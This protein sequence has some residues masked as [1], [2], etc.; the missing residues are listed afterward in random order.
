MA[1]WRYA[2]ANSVRHTKISGVRLGTHSVEAAF[3]DA[4]QIQHWLAELETYA[5]KQAS[6]A[7]L[8]L[9]VACKYNCHYDP[10]L[11]SRA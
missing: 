3:D 1:Y 6:K 5:A 8:M 10:H 7:L 2:H 4:A 9:V 11:A